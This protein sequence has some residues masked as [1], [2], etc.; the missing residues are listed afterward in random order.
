MTQR[1]S[2]ITTR[3]IIDAPIGSIYVIPGSGS[4]GYMKNLVE[5]LGRTDLKLINACDALRTVCGTRKHLIVDHA[6][7][8]VS[9]SCRDDAE[10]QEAV[11]Y[12]SRMSTS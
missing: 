12:V 9:K 1:G 5:F 11:A 6:Y 3:Q 8:D 10:L 7:Y 4:R 2:G